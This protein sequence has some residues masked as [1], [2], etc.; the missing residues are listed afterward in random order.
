VVG[1][2]QRDSKLGAWH[3]TGTLDLIK[4]NGGDD[5]EMSELNYSAKVVAQSGAT[6][7]MRA[8]PNTNATIL[9]PIRIGTIVQVLGE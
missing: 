9:E 5:R 7:N 2:I 1:G 8:N 4:Q 3:Y 6:V